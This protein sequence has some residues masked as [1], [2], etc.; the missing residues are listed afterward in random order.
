MKTPLFIRFNYGWNFSRKTILWQESRAGTASSQKT[1][2]ARSG[3]P[4]GGKSFASLAQIFFCVEFLGGK[5]CGRIAGGSRNYPPVSEAWEHQAKTVLRAER[6]DG[7]NGCFS[8]VVFPKNIIPLPFLF[9]IK[10]QKDVP[11]IRERPL[12]LI[13]RPN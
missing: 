1:A 13:F 11:P 7:R 4:K 12:P 8:T 3:V 5:I 6:A 2:A 10:K 9:L